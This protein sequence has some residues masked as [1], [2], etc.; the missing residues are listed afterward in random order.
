MPLDPLTNKH[1]RSATAMPIKSLT[2]LAVVLPTRTT[3]LQFPVYIEETPDGFVSKA[4][5]PDWSGPFATLSEA[6]QAEADAV[7]A[8][9]KS[10]PVH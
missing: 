10:G 6:I 7:L 2:I 8:D 5:R 4:I 3:S 9:M 1:A